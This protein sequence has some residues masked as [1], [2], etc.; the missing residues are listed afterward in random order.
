[1]RPG[2]PAMQMSFNTV[3]SVN[4]MRAFCIH[5]SW[6]A[7]GVLAQHGPA[8]RVQLRPMM[9]PLRSHENL[10]TLLGYSVSGFLLPTKKPRLC[11]GET[12]GPAEIMVT[13][14]YHQACYA[15]FSFN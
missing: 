4:A 11:C 13:V 6:K 1:M 2:E 7:A 8:F 15:C 14:F 10:K 12:E 9:K 3:G 5:G